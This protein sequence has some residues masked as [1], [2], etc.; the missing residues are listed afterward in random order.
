MIIKV[1]NDKV[2]IIL[3]ELYSIFITNMNSG[4]KINEKARGIY[5]WL[6]TFIIGTF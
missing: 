3:I 4:F 2:S 1:V 5:F 6:F